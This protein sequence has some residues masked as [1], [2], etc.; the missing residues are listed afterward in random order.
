[1]KNRLV[2]VGGV[3]G[4]LVAAGQAVGQSVQVELRDSSGALL[5][6]TQSFGS[7]AAINLGTIPTNVARVNVFSVGGLAAIGP[8]SLDA[9][10]RSGSLDVFLG[11]GAIPGIL[12]QLPQ[13]ATNWAGLDV[14]PA[15]QSKLRVA[16]GISGNI[17]GPVRAATITRLQV[18]GG[19]N[20][21]IDASGELGA[22]ADIGVIVAGSIGVD[23][24]IGAGSPG[25]PG[26]INSVTTTSGDLLGDVIATSEIG[27]VLASNGTLGN[28]TTRVAITAVDGIDS[29]VAK[30]INADVDASESLGAIREIRTSD[31]N[32]SGTVKAAA[33]GENEAIALLVNGSTN[34]SYDIGL[35][36]GMMR[37]TQS[38]TGAEASL[39]VDE[40]RGSVWVSGAA[41]SIFVGVASCPRT[42]SGEC[43]EQAG[44]LVWVE[45][46]LGMLTIGEVAAQPSPRNFGVRVNAP[47]INDLNVGTFRGQIYWNNGITIGPTQ[48]REGTIG[49]VEQSDGEFPNI[50]LGTYIGATQIRR[51]DVVDGFASDAVATLELGESFATGPES[52]LRI[53]GTLEDSF[54]SIGVAGISGLRGQVILDDVGTGALIEIWSGDAENPTVTTLDAANVNNYP[55]LPSV[56]GGGAVG[57]IP[58]RAHVAS[59][60]ERNIDSIEGWPTETQF[61]TDN[62]ICELSREIHIDMYGPVRIQSPAL[63]AFKVERN[64]GGTWVDLSPRV[65]FETREAV[66]GAGFQRI[67]VLRGK[68]GY[69]LPRGTYR[70]TPTNYEVNGVGNLVCDQ[71]LTTALVP[72]SSDLSYEFTLQPDCNTNCIA[73]VNEPGPVTCNPVPICDPIDFNN[74]AVFP[75]DQD[76]I[77]YMNVTA[78]GGCSAGN[79]CNDIDFNNDGVFPDE[80]DVIDFFNVLAGAECSNMV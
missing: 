74:D 9:S 58:F 18:G 73:D 43:S 46:P 4:I 71:L 47:F 5:G 22:A 23:G 76:L 75:D 77:D 16:A 20:A 19:I 13:V 78:G 49:R 35:L 51:L 34:A 8:M 66:T 25:N 67:V 38:F 70:V 65:V 31:G 53:G 54:V 37:V 7:G 11:E 17:T 26:F 80:Q 28:A 42:A 69:G 2:V 72:V 60:D 63:P 1:M 62:Q 15:T 3:F 10:N 30:A 29:V 21:E 52:K 64:F 45:G 50:L 48:L 27:D 44:S 61:N 12:S 68:P 39:E 40:L 57:E 14:S 33:L 55:T 56:L 24:D 41:D 6:S 59:S 32:L 79:T 36:T